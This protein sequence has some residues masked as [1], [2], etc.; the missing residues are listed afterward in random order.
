MLFDLTFFKK[1]K[2]SA[3][4]AVSQDG[5]AL[6]CAT[7]ELRDDLEVVSAAIAQ[8]PEAIQ[9]ASKRIKNNPELLQESEKRLELIAQYDDYTIEEYSFEE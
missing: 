5:W 3:L 1:D 2:D 4:A 9:Y 6:A 8:N 7:P